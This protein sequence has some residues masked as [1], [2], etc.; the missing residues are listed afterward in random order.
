MAT[1]SSRCSRSYHRLNSAS[2]DGS[3]SIDVSSIPFPASG[4][5]EKSLTGDFRGEI[6]DRLHHGIADAGIV[7][8][9]AGAL[10]QTNFRTGPHRV[11]RMRGCRRTQQIVAALHDEAG[12][13]LELSRFGEKLVRLHEAV[14][15]EI[16]RFHERRGGQ[17]P[18]RVQRIE[19]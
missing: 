18:C 17:C 19:I 14:V 10:D 7:Q 4:I 12:D 1:R 13:R 11:E 2:S 6:R 5:S 8:R 3:I 9:M 16:M 15:L